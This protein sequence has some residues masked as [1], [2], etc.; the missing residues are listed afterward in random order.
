M[1]IKEHEFLLNKICR[2]YTQA[3]QDRQDLF[4]E[5]V[6]Q[7]WKSYPNFK[8]DAKIST[9]MYKV[10]IY[11]S[12]TGL[13]KKKNFIHSTEPENLPQVGSELQYDNTKDKQLENLYTAIAQLNE[14]EKAI[15]MLY[16]ENKNYAEMEEI[17]GI[18][19]GNLR[20]KMNRIKDKLKQIIKS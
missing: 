11:T 18:N 9:W 12:I 20:V 10:A 3:L 15:I 8:G 6:I 5:I 4:Q 2:V 17:M 7:L 1:L 14:I 19:Q 13:R 16:L